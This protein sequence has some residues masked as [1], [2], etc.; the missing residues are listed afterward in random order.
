MPTTDKEKRRTINHRHRETKRAKKQ[1]EREAV[2]QIPDPLES[3]KRLAEL[4]LVRIQSRE[5]TGSLVP[6][7][8]SSSFFNGLIIYCH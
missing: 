8:T 2:A 5:T 3:S 6:V 1:A 7:R 4:V